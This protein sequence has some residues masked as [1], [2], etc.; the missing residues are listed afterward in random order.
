MAAGT[1]KPPNAAIA[2]RVAPF[3]RASSPLHDFTFDFKA[4][5]RKKTAI[6][7]SL[8]QC[9]SVLERATEPILISPVACNRASYCDAA[10]E[11]AGISAAGPST[12]P[13]YRSVLL[14]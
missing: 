6:R 7:P 14:P 4:I 5:R 11:L 13:P 2:G 12:K 8:I 3:R 1:T 9:S 10:G